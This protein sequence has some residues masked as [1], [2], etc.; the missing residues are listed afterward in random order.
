[1]NSQLVAGCIRSGRYRRS[2]R[3]SATAKSIAIQQCCNIAEPMSTGH[4]T[5]VIKL[6]AIKQRHVVGRNTDP[7]DAVGYWRFVPLRDHRARTDRS[8]SDIDRR[9]ARYY[10]AKKMTDNYT[11]S[12][13]SVISRRS[14]AQPRNF[15]GGV[16]R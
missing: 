5:S 14:P 2:P 12:C 9:A 3:H 11:V 10:T 1:M 16:K 4:G 7:D 6:G 8:C 13:R 15:L